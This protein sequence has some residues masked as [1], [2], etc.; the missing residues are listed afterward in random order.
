[1]EMMRIET[2][3]AATSPESAGS[4]Q[5]AEFGVLQSAPETALE[6]QCPTCH[7]KVKDMDYF[8]ANCGANLKPVP[9]ATS[10]GKQFRL[11]LGSIL[12]PPMG[13]IW[14]WR[15]LKQDSPKSKLVGGVAILLTVVASIVV[16]VYT[17]KL[18]SQ[19]NTKVNNQLNNLMGF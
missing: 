10:V 15:Y 17:I 9:P 18:M 11:Y 12:L 14:G 2:P 19:V 8:C 5:T 4:K 16:T 1:M 6:G 7:V 3:G 13:I